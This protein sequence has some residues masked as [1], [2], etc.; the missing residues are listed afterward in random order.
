MNNQEPTKDL[1][2]ETNEQIP[3]PLK[4]SF[5]TKPKAQGSE[6]FL[7]NIQQLKIST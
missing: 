2:T 5:K 4:Y 7:L 6:R 1:A 3:N